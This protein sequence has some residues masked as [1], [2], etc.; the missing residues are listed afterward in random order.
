ML[1]VAAGKSR[2]CFAHMVTERAHRKGDTLYN[3]EK[4]QLFR[5]TASGATARFNTTDKKKI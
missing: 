2:N 3:Q 1:S 4:R 5:F